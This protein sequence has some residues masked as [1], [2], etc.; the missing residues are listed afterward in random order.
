M[1]QILFYRLEILKN[2][3]V[4][5][6]RKDK[7]LKS[8]NHAGMEVSGDVIIFVFGKANDLKMENA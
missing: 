2:F 8:F 3:L 4:C 7:T 6:I 5:H 1:C